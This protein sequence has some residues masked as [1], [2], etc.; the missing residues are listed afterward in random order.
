MK[1][2]YIIL[3]IFFFNMAN[4]FAEYPY[5]IDFS[6]VLNNSK[7]GADAQ[8]KLK[9]KFEID[10]K[11]YSS[12]EVSL[13]KQ[14]TDIISQKKMITNEEYQIKIEALRKKVAEHQIKKKKAFNNIAKARGEAKKSLLEAVNPIIKKYMAENNIK[15]IL[16]KKS[17]L[18]G[19][20]NLEIT[21]QIISILN[22]EISSLK[23]N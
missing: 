9:K 17:V 21:N 23:I 16:D 10:S 7:A 20:S 12:E 14:E 18:M 4:S 1:F 15:L 5:F 8:K 6:K 22:K 13:R 3:I 2:F 19:D 11:K